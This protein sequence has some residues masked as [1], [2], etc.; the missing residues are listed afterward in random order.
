[1]AGPG[2]LTP[3]RP[4]AGPGRAA[5]IRHALPLAALPV[6]PLQGAWV[7][8]RVPRFADADGRTGVVGS[9]DRTLRLVV[10]GDSVAAGY[11]VPH[12]RSTV[13]GALA[14]RLSERYAAVVEWSVVATT[15]FTAGEATGLVR[16]PA[17]AAT[18]AE[19]DV[20]FLSIGVNDT[21]NLHSAARFRRELGGLLDAVLD[22]APRAEVL[23]L[24]IPPLDQLPAVPRPLAD[25]LGWRG[26]IFDR[27]SAQE[28]ERR[29]RVHRLWPA[30]VLM[31][32]MFAGDGFHPSELLHAMFADAAIDALTP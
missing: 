20:V 21:K 4:P 14:T 15:G 10:L 17:A 9:G 2:D 3:V 22:Q 25:A 16:D 32:E 24:G 26:R 12:H 5:R 11:A 30:N 18:F 8:R 1:M 6:A 13:T 27:I 28:C 31:R 19:A 7:T 29:D 23:V